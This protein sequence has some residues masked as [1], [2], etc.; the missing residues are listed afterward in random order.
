MSSPPP[1]GC[2]AR[3]HSTFISDLESPLRLIC[4][5]HELDCPRSER[6]PIAQSPSPLTALTNS[7]SIR[8]ATLRQG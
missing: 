3:F 7:R 1:T 5:V 8:D 4:Q 2:S 6:G